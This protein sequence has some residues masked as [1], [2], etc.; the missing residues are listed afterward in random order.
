MMIKVN[1]EDARLLLRALQEY[2]AE[3]DTAAECEADRQ[4]CERLWRDIRDRLPVRPER[5]GQT[6]V[7]CYPRDLAGAVLAPERRASHW[8]TPID[9]IDQ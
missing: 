3:G 1:D 4:R 6:D 2:E 8:R 5:A 7:T 9:G